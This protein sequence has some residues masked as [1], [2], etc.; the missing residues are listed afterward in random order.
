[1]CKREDKKKCIKER[2]IEV[3]DKYNIN[4]TKYK[5]NINI[6]KKVEFDVIFLPFS[7]KKNG[8]KER[9]SEK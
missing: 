2:Y 9:N 1:M 3:R 6:A 8:K 7:Y 5:Y 4:N